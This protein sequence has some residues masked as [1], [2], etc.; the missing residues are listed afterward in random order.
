MARAAWYATYASGVPRNEK[1]YLAIG[2]LVWPFGLAI[3]AFRQWHRPWAMNAF[4]LFCIFFAFTFVIADE[5]GSDS[6][7]YAAEFVE[8][9]HSDISLSDVTSLFYVVDSDSTDIVYP[10]ILFFLSRITDNPRFLF[11]VFAILM[12]YFFSRN[13]WYILE[14]ARGRF[15]GMIM[16]FFITFILLNPIWNINGFRF[17]L[18]SQIFL[19]GTLP[20]LLDG[21][22]KSLIWSGASVLV[23][24]TFLFPVAVLGVYLLMKNRT[25][26]YL[27]FFII[28]SLI[29]EINMEWFQSTLSF[30]PDVIF[31]EISSYMRP[32]YA[33]YRRAID[34]ELPWFLPFSDT[35]IRWTI[36]LILISAYFFGGDTLKQR[37]DLKTLLSFTLLFFGFANILSQVPSGGR[38]L[39]VANTFMFPFIILFLKAVPMVGENFLV[40]VVTFPL[41]CLFCLVQVRI[42]MD[43]FSIMTLIGNP[44]TIALY[45]EPFPLIDQLKTI[46]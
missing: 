38:F 31:T 5:N 3:E 23:H 10:L 4:W 30:L 2:F 45:T 16:L 20:Y 24:F 28:T 42:G 14:K 46:I 6:G 13:I 11:V 39:V 29:Q 26:L 1:L 7:R 44:V 22:K 15:P 21:R 25:N 37:P 12:G 27:I 35:G 40:K 36:Y 43:H 19:F 8:F 32:E 33:E 9:A 41:L 34:E 18:A 17:A